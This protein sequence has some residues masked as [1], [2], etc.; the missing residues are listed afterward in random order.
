MGRIGNFGGSRVEVASGTGGISLGF[1]R[2]GYQDDHD[3]A[4]HPRGDQGGCRCGTWPKLQQLQERPAGTTNGRA[5]R[6]NFSRSNSASQKC[7]VTLITQI[8]PVARL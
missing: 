4:D 2:L 7:D 3:L 1:G 8:Y 5:G 6:M